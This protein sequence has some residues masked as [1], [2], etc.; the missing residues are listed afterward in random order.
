MCLR[1]GLIIYT[2]KLYLHK[3]M[4]L[5]QLFDLLLLHV[6]IKEGSS[7]LPAIIPIVM[8]GHE[9]ANPRNGAVLPKPNDLPPI[10]DAVI[11]ESLEGNG[12]MDALRLLGLGVNLLLPFLTAAA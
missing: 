2:I 11:L 1:L 3:L 6:L 5:N 12:L 8:L 10:L 7:T 4:T 9:A